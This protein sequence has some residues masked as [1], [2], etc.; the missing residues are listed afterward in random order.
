MARRWRNG[1]E[2]N[3]VLEQDCERF[4]A[5]L[6][7]HRVTEEGRHGRWL[8]KGDWTW[9]EVVTLSNGIYVGGDIET[10]VFSGGSD[11]AAHPRGRVYWMA[12]TSYGYA[13][14]KARH[15]GTA[16]EEW[17]VE[18]ARGELLWH[19]QVDQLSKDQ[20]RRL[21]NELKR[22]PS[23]ADF[24]NAVYRETQDAELCDMGEVVNASVYMATAVLRRLAH[25][26][27]CQDFQGAS[28]EWFRRAA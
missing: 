21:W 10:V 3:Q 4:V 1:L 25:L 8:L 27:D 14:E 16:P 11:R 20:A 6:R 24:A 23:Q 28:A 12:T 7:L 13:S 19:R 22:E 9:A 17:D 5:R 2:R 15:G 18:C 26:L